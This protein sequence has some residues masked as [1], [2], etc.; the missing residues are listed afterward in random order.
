MKSER[1][2]VLTIVITYLGSIHV[3][4]LAT[5][6]AKATVLVVSSKILYNLLF[7]SGFKMQSKAAVRTVI[8]VETVMQ[9]V[10]EAKSKKSS[11]YCAISANT[12]ASVI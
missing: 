12:K 5:T 2:I 7:L 4:I 3:A 8:T 11:D 1:T 9:V 10:E 6:K